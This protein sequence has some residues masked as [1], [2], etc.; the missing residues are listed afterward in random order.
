M[1]RLKIIGLATGETTG[2]DGKFVKEYDPSY[3][4]PGEE[5]DGGLLE[6][7]DDPSEALEF[8]SAKEALECWRRE[9][10]MRPDGRPNRPLTA[11]TVEVA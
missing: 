6:V 5:Y 4:L 2:F 3:R 1:P 9:Y 10:G 11:F 8:P 7:T